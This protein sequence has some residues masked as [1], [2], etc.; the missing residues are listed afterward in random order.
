STLCARR[1]IPVP[2]TYCHSPER[3]HERIRC[4]PCLFALV[5]PGITHLQPVVVVVRGL[6]N[7]GVC[8]SCAPMSG[9]VGKASPTP[10]PR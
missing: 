1:Q 5:H 10:V 9:K 3:E 7:D 2:S 6:A 8:S 4:L